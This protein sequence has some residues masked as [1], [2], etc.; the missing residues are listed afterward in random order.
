M[1]KTIS[2]LL[3]LSLAF[4]LFAQ[5]AGDIVVLYDNDVHCA[6]DGYPVIA[7]LRDSLEAKGCHVAVVSAGD[8]SFGGPLGAVSKGEYIVRIMNAVG[9]D[10]ACLGNHEFDFGLLQLRHISSQLSAPLLCCNFR[11]NDVVQKP[12][13]NLL[14]LT[15]VV[16]DGREDTLYANPYVPSVIRRYG[17]INVAFVGVT[18]PTTKYTSS[19]TSFQDSYG[20][21]V[22]NFSSL[23]L[24]ESVQCA[25]DA[26]RAAGADV[27]VLLSHLGDSG[28]YPTSVQI[29]SQ[30]TGVDV[31]L[32]GHDHHV[33]PSRSVTDRT[34]RKVLLSSTGTRFQYMGVLTLPVENG[35]LAGTPSTRLLPTDSLLH[36][37]CLNTAVADTVRLLKEQFETNGKRVVA[38]S[39]SPLVAEEGDIRVCRLRETNLGDLVADAFRLVFGA[40]IGWVNGGSIRANLPAGPVS[41]NQL[42]AALPYNNRTVLIRT[43]G[44]DIL[45]ALEIALREY[46]K[47]NGCFAQVSGISFSV[48]T[49]VPSGVVIDNNGFFQRVEGRR[50]ISEVYVG[51]QPLLPEAT[52]TIAGSVYVLLGGGDAVVFP[53]KE[54]LQVGE[55]TDIQVLEQYLTENLQGVIAPPYNSPQRRIIFKNQ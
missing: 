3:G 41:F 42:L 19:P 2:F 15:N 36:V 1:R 39:L 50:R 32:D 54:V 28:G 6:V 31:I 4:T 40:D 46:P 14:S 7:G 43:T 25:V 55:L 12:L 5:Q 47:A 52:Y 34:G 26:V 17:S 45:D 49:T 38:Y 53:H 16:G 33:I 37:G 35:R 10:A 23:S 11:F 20:H 27:V 44:Q 18:T 13:A 30:V 29:A 8:F 21:P 51:S 9:Y 48:D 22:Y 24:A